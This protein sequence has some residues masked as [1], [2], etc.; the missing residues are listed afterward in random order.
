MTSC[1]ISASSSAT[2]IRAT[3]PFPA[4]HQTV[5]MELIVR[6]D[7]L[8]EP[9]IER[10]V[11]NE[12]YFHV[13]NLGAVIDSNLPRFSQAVQAVA[14]A[15]AFLLDVRWVVPILGLVLLGAVVG[16][17]RWNLLAAI[18]RRL[19]VPRGEPEPAAPPRF[20]QT[21]G[22]IFL[23]VGTVGLF[24]LAAHTTAWWI[25]GWGAALIVAVLAGLAATTS[26]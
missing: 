1:R 14:L 12:H 19:P 4:L 9:G 25:V 13:A 10:F 6:L 11:R 3:C 24:G 16:G 20:A 2:R 23:A 7:R 18:Y 26:F 5:S 15:V 21:L 22:T 8:L 17:P